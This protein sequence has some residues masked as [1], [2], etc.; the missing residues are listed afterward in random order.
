M[1]QA[2]V[3]EEFA[4]ALL[5]DCGDLKFAGRL[6]KG[7]WMGVTR[8]EDAIPSDFGD[9]RLGGGDLRI[10]AQ[11]EGHELFR[12]ILDTSRRRIAGQG[13]NRI[14]YRVSR[15]DLAVITVRKTRFK[16]PS[17]QYLHVPLA[18]FVMVRMAFDAHESDTRFAV[19]VFGKFHHSASPV[20]GIA[21]RAE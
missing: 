2:R 14:F 21:V 19:A 5:L 17:K 13:I 15:K 10:A 7:S 18:E 11:Q 8:D 4:P 12:E 3:D 16:I 1:V 9:F 6:L 20:S